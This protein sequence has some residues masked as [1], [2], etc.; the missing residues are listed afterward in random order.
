MFQTSIHRTWNCSYS[1]ESSESRRRKTR[2][3]WKQT[4]K[5]TRPSRKRQTWRHGFFSDEKQISPRWSNARTRVCLR[6]IFSLRIYPEIRLIIGL[7][8][9]D[10][11]S[12]LALFSH[13]TLICFPTPFERVLLLIAGSDQSAWF[14]NFPRGCGNPGKKSISKVPRIPVFLR[15]GCR[16]SCVFLPLSTSHENCIIWVESGA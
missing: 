5:N 6:H 13:T 14:Q 10:F 1:S 7:V 2:I 16:F 3:L 9:C 12:A 4:R 11:L 15:N 8:S